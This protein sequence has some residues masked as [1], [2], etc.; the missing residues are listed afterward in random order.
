MTGDEVTTQVCERQE[1]ERQKWE[2][3]KWGRS[4]AW[5][6]KIADYCSSGEQLF[7]IYLL[8]IPSPLPLWERVRV[9]SK[10][11][12]LWSRKIPI[13]RSKR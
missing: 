13:L 8:P 2:R 9:R 4:D 1:W 11:V 5:S 12:R 7:S 3:Q 10:R 6:N